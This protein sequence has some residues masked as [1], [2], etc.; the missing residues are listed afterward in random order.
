MKVIVAISAFLTAAALAGGPAFGQGSGAT[1][2]GS[3]GDQVVAQQEEITKSCA[4]LADWDKVA[5]IKNK[6]RERFKEAHPCVTSAM[7]RPCS[8]LAGPNRMDCIKQK[9]E[10]CKAQ[11][12]EFKAER[13]EKFKENHP[14]AAAVIFTP[15]S[16]LTGDA[17]K[18]CRQEQSAKCK[19]KKEEVKAAAEERRAQ[20]KEKFME[21]HPCAANVIYTPCNALSGAELTTCRAQQSAKCKAKS[22]N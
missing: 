17:Q 11:R 6:M 12:E 21:N 3:T 5:C 20:R 9:M 16:S 19:A 18:T 15:C 14:C 2:L 8:H 13:K 10:E 1:G 4:N 7:E 22:G